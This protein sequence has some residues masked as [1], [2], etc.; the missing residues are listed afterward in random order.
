LK[1]A[2]CA[3]AYEK[4]QESRATGK[5]R[6]AREAL[7]ICAQEACPNFVQTDCA[8]W[9]TEVQRELPT[10]VISVKDKH[11]DDTVD[12]KVSMDGEPFLEALDGKGAAVDPGMHKF[13]FELEGADPIDQQILIRQGQKDRVVEVSFAKRGAQAPEP[14]PYGNATPPPEAAPPADADSGKPGPLR[15]YAYVA[16]GVGAAGI[17]G[18]VAFGAMGRSKESDLRD[19]CSP[20]CPQSEVDSAKTKYL[21]ANISLGLGI[22]GL[23]TGV[24]LFFL[25]QPKGKPASNDQ[26]T[27]LKLDV[28]T[29]PGLAYAG[30]SGRF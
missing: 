16:G 24:A 3:A 30:L 13:R 20:N 6:D 19:T 1:K 8:Q 18:W 23:G 4:S 14:S 29:S 26:A 28:R 21:L 9:L 27:S 22:A 17:L 25:S 5:L 12:V 10:I 2:E 11:G 15:P 7:V